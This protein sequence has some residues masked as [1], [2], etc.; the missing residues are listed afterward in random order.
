MKNI[1]FIL[2]LVIGFISCKKNNGLEEEKPLYE[3]TTYNGHKTPQ[4]G[5]SINYNIDTTT[6]NTTIVGGKDISWSFT[7]LKKQDS[8]KTYYYDTTG[9][10]YSGLFPSAK[11]TSIVNQELVYLGLTTNGLE[12]QG[13]V[14]PVADT[15]FVA[16][17]NKP[18]NQVDFPLNYLDYKSENYSCNETKYNLQILI[19]GARTSVDSLNLFRSGT[20][21]KK[22]DG[23]G[24]L[25]MPN[26]TY[27]VLR[28]FKEETVADTVVA[29]MFVGFG[30]KEIV[31]VEK[32][33][34][35]RTYEFVTDSLSTPLLIVNLNENIEV[36]HVRFQN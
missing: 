30:T 2:I 26:K 25:K 8:V 16:L 4:I 29:H 12:V 33:T 22:V 15:E 34:I 14:I 3:C 1:A 21:T 19:N 28:I 24:T 11:Y 13:A 23:C 20:I 10:K 7:G 5:D 6:L 36:D 27:E 35:Y 17:Y 32:E 18:Y 9:L 31:M